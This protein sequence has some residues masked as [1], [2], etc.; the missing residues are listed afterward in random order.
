MLVPM[1]SPDR[2]FEPFVHLVDATDT[3]VLVAWGG[4]FLEQ[5]DGTWKVVDDDD[6]HGGR[7]DGHGTIGA[8][9]ASYGV[10]VVEVLGESGEVVAS[11]TSSEVNH[12]WV[13]GLQPDTAYR[14][15]VRVDDEVWADGEL[16]DWQTDLGGPTPSGRTYDLRFRTHPAAEATVP[17][18]FLAFGDYGVGIAT[19][20]SGQRQ[21]AVART[22]EALSKTHPVRFLVSLGDNIYHRG[23][24]AETQSGDEDDDWYLTFYEPYRYLLDH[25]PLYPAAG[26]HDG[27]DTEASDDREQLADNFHLDARFGPRVASGR[28]ELETGLFYALR[29]GGLLEI[30]CIDTSW[31]EEGG[32]HDF[33]REQSQR[34]LA[35]AMPPGGG[36]GPFPVWR[37]PFCHH[38]AY[39]AGPHHENMVTQIE[40][41]VPFFRRAGVRLVLS[42]HEHNFQHGRVDGVDYVISGA[43]GKLQEE[44]PMRW[45]DGGT[46]SWASEPHCLLVRVEEDRITVTPYGVPGPGGQPEPLRVRAPDGGEVP[47]EFVLV[48]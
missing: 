16:W 17:V 1:T 6:L 11:A 22:L 31:A 7:Q 37:I 18:T 43:A 42:G 47:A 25:L 27:A 45:E 21:Q 5:R 38:P 24:D 23:D 20:E 13:E 39:C 41:V 10:G 30:V 8:K 40:H 48:R 44:P 19:G 32:G 35:D 28:A 34:W 33:D 2:R 4:F 29:I 26:N 9:S 46:I 36:E 12:V 14:Y 3:S 15:R